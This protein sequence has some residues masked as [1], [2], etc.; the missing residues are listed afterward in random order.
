MDNSYILAIG[1]NVNNI[2]IVNNLYQYGG[3]GG[4]IAIQSFNEI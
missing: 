2:G 3:S 4:R 1:G